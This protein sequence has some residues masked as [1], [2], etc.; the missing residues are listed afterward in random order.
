M[1]ITFDES[2][3]QGHA[4]CAA[5]GSDFYHLDEVGHCSL[6][7][8]TDVP[9]GLEDQAEQGAAACPELALSVVK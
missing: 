2:K 5:H 7:K 1:Q 4:Q 9:T 3:C 6:S 8:V